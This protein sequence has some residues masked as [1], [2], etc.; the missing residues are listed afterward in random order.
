MLPQFLINSKK[1]RVTVFFILLFALVIGSEKS[2]AFFQDD[3]QEEADYVLFKG[4][5]VDSDNRKP[6]VFASLMVENTNI[7]TITN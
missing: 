6:L 7:S 5:V 1:S 2:S 3:I 4:E